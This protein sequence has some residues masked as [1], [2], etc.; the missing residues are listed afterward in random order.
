M[1]ATLSHDCDIKHT[2]TIHIIFLPVCSQVSMLS[3]RVEAVNQHV[4]V[5]DIDAVVKHLRS[6]TL[7]CI[8]YCCPT[9]M[10]ASVS[11]SSYVAYIV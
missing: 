5:F 4:N 11:S 2:C 7:Y 9:H 1:L 8:H 10:Q 3:D 6:V